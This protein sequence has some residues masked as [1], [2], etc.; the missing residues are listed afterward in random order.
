MTN[1]NKRRGDQAELEAARI[2]HNHLGYP[3]RRKLGAGRT[4]DTGDIYG[5]P[6]TVIQVCSRNTDVVA[7]G[8]VRKPIECEQQQLNA[9]APFGFTMLR[10][11]GGTWRIVMTVEQLCELWR[12]ATA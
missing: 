5:L 12:E 11:R 6:D 7:V 10:I 2:L 1:P 8:I 9:N 4:D 3:T